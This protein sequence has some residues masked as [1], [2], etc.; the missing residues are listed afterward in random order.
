MTCPLCKKLAQQPFTP[1]C[2]QRCKTL[3]LN[4]WFQGVYAIPGEDFVLESGD[5]DDE[6]Q[7]NGQA[8]G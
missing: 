3:D 4:R 1:F 5:E 2:S 6:S 8:L 7:G